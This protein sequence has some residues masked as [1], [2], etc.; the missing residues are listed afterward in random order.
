VEESEAA[1]KRPPLSRRVSRARLPSVKSCFRV[2][3]RFPCVDTLGWPLNSQLPAGSPND[4]HAGTA[5][6]CSVW[7]RGDPPHRRRRTG[8]AR[9]LGRRRRS[10]RARTSVR[11]RPHPRG[12]REGKLPQGTYLSPLLSRGAIAASLTRGPFSLLADRT[13]VCRRA[14]ARRGPGLQGSAGPPPERE[15]TLR[16]RRHDLRKVSSYLLRDL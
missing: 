1:E 3:C 4:G 14:I 8:T 13:P 7:R 10:S 12:N 6:S 5:I 16:T 2:N 11:S 9:R 15:R